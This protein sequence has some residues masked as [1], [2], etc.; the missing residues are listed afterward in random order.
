MSRQL[1]LVSTVAFWTIVL[2]FALASNLWNPSADG[3]AKARE[4]VISAA[5]LSRH[6][7]PQDCWMAIRGSVY[8]LGAYLPD[9]P[10]RPDVIVPWCGRD[11]TAAYET[12]TKGRPHSPYADKLL[13]QYLIGRFAGTPGS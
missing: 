8:D 11:A 1:Y 9:H 12:K 10:S 6:S 4:K 5:E 2:G 13:A 7:T 3:A